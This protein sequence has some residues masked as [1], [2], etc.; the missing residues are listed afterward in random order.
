MAD[1]PEKPKYVPPLPRD[2]IPV[3]TKPFRSSHKEK[4]WEERVEDLEDWRRE[5]DPRLDRMANE[6]YDEVSDMTAAAIRHVEN[7]VKGTASKDEL[8]KV[9]EIA[10]KTLTMNEAQTTL[11]KSAADELKEA[12]EERLKRSGAEALLAQQKAVAKEE[13]D[14]RNRRL[15]IYVPIIVAIVGL[16]GTLAALAVRSQAN[17]PGHSVQQKE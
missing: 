10:E 13:R 16:V 9:K 17:P 15:A 6:I 2:S 12:R 14:A 4:T 8:S 5:V 7:A 3:S 1:K 11:L